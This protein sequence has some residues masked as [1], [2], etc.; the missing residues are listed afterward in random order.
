VKPGKSF[1][2]NQK[3]AETRLSDIAGRSAARRPCSNHNCVITGLH[4]NEYS[5][6]VYS[7]IVEL[8]SKTRDQQ[9]TGQAILGGRQ[10]V[11]V[12]SH[13]PNAL[14]FQYL[15]NLPDTSCLETGFTSEVGVWLN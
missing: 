2:F 7:C 8:S 6:I 14:Q 3:G 9:S 12:I 15:L 4:G 1:A 11:K 13:A 5:L 10:V